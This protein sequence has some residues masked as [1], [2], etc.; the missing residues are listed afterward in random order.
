MDLYFLFF[1]KVEQAS[2]LLQKLQ[3]LGGGMMRCV[4][5]ISDPVNIMLVRFR[6]VMSGGEGTNPTVN[7]T[8]VRGLS[9]CE[10]SLYAHFKVH[11]Y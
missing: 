7:H 6:F 1:S 8:K 2:Y 11:Y 10:C 9:S 5:L 4:E 3:N